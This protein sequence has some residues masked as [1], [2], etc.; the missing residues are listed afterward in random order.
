MGK[1]M[2]IKEG[3]EVLLYLNDKNSWIVKIEKGKT[4][5]THK[6]VVK[7]DD[8]IGKSYGC[9][10]Q[11]NM[12]VSLKVLPLDYIDYLE[13]IIRKTQIIYPKDLCYICFQANIHPGSIV[14]EAGTGSGVLTSYIANL[15]RPDGKVYTYEIREEFQKIAKKNIE[16]LGLSKYVE[17]KLKDITKGIDERNVDAVI[18]DM[19]TPWLVVE[20]AKKA[21]KI[22]GR[23]VSFSPTINQVEKTV[24]AM[25]LAGFINIKTIELIIRRYKVKL[26]ETRPE[27][28]MI[29]HTGYITSGRK[30][31]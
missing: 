17:F 10:I 5:H 4:F 11:T 23:F 18:L 19:A 30:V 24:E 6:G 31:S 29:G 26:N 22:G 15:I 14:V 27:T 8:I 3:D 7:L 1:K 2:E 13:R 20:E 28:I 25:K 12:A 9:E 21:L 16:R